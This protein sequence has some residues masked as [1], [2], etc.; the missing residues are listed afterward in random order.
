MTLLELLRECER[1]RKGE[2]ERREK[3]E[4]SETIEMR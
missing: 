4:I 3:R 1:G 2:G